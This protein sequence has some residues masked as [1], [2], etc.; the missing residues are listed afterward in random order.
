MT[1]GIKGG[2][3]FVGIEFKASRIQRWLP[4]AMLPSL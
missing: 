4:D 2:A 1:I 3:I